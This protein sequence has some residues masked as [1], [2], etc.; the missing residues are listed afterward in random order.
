ML[1]ALHVGKVPSVTPLIVTAIAGV[2]LSIQKFKEKTG[3]TEEDEED[4]KVQE[5]EKT[6]EEKE[7]DCW[8]DYY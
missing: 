8:A 3:E 5:Q 1:A 6:Y 4:A 7:Q 2:G